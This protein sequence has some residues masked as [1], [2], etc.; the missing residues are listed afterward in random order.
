[1]RPT[2][3]SLDNAVQNYA[4]GSTTAIAALLGRPSPGGLPE[5]ELWIG[6]HPKAP[7]RAIDGSAE[8][9]LDEWIRRDPA[10]TLGPAVAAR[11]GELPFLLKVLAA[12]EPLS[13]QCHPNA[14][15]ARAGFTRENEGGLS[16][17][18][19]RR[20]YR[21]PNH[22]PELLV[23]LT[24]FLA[25]KGFRPLE[26]IMA[27]FA[28][29]SADPLREALANLSRARD[30]GAL[31]QLFGA[32]LSLDRD[33]RSLLLSQALATAG[34][35]SDP[36][37]RWVGRLHDKY[38][39]D[40][41][42]LAPLLLNLIELQ[43]DEALFLGAG[44]LHAYLE[45]TGL[46]LMANSDNVLRGGLTPKHV[47]AGELLAVARFEGGPPEVL[48]P[49]R[50]ADTERIYRTPASE[51][52]LSLIDLSPEGAYVAPPGR[53]VELLL[54][55]SGNACI[56]ADGHTV[57]LSQGRSAFVPAAVP[58]YRIEG[59]GRVCRARVPGGIEPQGGR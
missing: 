21:D 5:A 23:A 3:V 18:D 28:A 9:R 51:F 29:F 24:R 38:P 17:A 33:A 1:M 12:A 37:W 40:V 43:P 14:E 20:N 19:P 7:S 59:E 8:C 53:G 47:D 42:T 54:G 10:A 45:G 48:R 56:V 50:L 52:Q 25:L 27:F 49:M 32:L 6:A 58:S 41:G 46:E 30:A 34:R 44:E 57:P 13:I 15:Q 4:W 55:L 31:K 35:R 2:I 22:K 39:G 16:F 11:Y 26:E 36:A